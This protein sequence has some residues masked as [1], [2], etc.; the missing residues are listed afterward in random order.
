MAATNVF[1]IKGSEVERQQ[2]CVGEYC[3]FK[4]SVF[5]CLAAVG[6]EPWALCTLGECSTTEL[7]P[8]RPVFQ[9]ASAVVT[10]NFTNISWEHHLPSLTYCFSFETVIIGLG[11]QL[12]SRALAWHVQGLWFDSQCCEKQQNHH[13]KRWWTQIFEQWLFSKIVPSSPAPQHTHGELYIPF[14]GESLS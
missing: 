5:Y 14:S 10:I 6:K 9:N 1:R 8:R 7:C 11:I 4:R 12:I 13:R 3:A 2:Y